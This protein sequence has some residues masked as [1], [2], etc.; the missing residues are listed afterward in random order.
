MVGWFRA[1]WITLVVLALLHAGTALA[2]GERVALV[3][4][5]G[6]YA[7]TTRL[8]NP[9]HDA[10]D[11]AAALGRLGFEVFRVVDGDKAT[12]ERTIRS[13]GNGLAGAEVALFFYAGHGLQVAGRNY[14]LPINARLV[15]EQDLLFEAIDVALPL[16]V[17]E[18]AGV[19]VKL[20]FLD[21]CRDNPL[22]R[23]LARSLRSDG[24]SADIGRGLARIEGATGTLIAYATAPGDIAA[25]GRGRNSP[26][27]AGLLNWIDKP[28]LEVRAMLGRVR[29]SVHKETNGRQVPWVNESLL[30]EL[31][32]RP[33]EI[34]AAPATPDVGPPVPAP[35]SPGQAT[36][37][38]EIL[39]WRSIKDSTRPEDFDAYLAQFP[40]GIFAGLARNRVRALRQEQT[41]RTAPPLSELELEPVEAIYITLTNT[42][43]REQPSV[44]SATLGTLARG[45]QVHVAGRV[46]G[47]NWY[48]VERGGKPLGYVYGELLAAADRSRVA[49]T[50]PAV[51]TAPLVPS[52]AGAWE[53]SY[54]RVEL[55]V[56]GQRVTGR[57]QYNQ[58]RLEGQISPDGRT[59]D[60]RWGEAPS[61]QPPSKAGAFRFTLN[62]DGQ[63][64]SGGWWSGYA[65]T[66][67]PN[68]WV[69]ERAR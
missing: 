10:E 17:M 35:A 14:L 11:V 64:F 40:N 30:G 16:S 22:A 28:G 51:P 56:D 27:T 66:G 5:N 55:R 59:L 15:Q 31:Y 8:A 13:F 62:P 48:L 37:E 69:G 54:G 42:N 3:I 6:N 25:D 36:A 47:R 43:V 44:D 67:S 63:S 19:R 7:E 46:R 58:G 29:E 24:R 34:I 65:K 52:W 39:F 20:V 49:L 2:A 1:G 26:F 4:G 61:Y 32:L 68:R 21:A 23:S 60:G 12:M 33:T 53:T 50:A 57:Y 45:T 18:Q 38:H 9:P 41:S